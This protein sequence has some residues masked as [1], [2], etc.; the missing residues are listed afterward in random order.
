M[1]QC[2]QNAAPN[3][4]KTKNTN[5][6]NSLSKKKKL[7]RSELKKKKIKNKQYKKK[8]LNIKLDQECKGNTPRGNT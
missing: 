8:D 2:I 1:F 6:K 4:K 7:N 3:K 5:E